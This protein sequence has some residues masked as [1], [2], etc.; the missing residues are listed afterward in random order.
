M[1]DIRILM[2]YIRNS[3]EKARVSN[4]FDRLCCKLELKALNRTI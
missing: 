2:T 3:E 1:T 4:H